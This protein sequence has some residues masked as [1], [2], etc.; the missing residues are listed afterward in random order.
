MNR[1]S[2]LFWLVLVGLSSLG[3]TC[4]TTDECEA[5]QKPPIEPIFKIDFV[6]LHDD[7]SPYTGPV[8]VQF[9]KNYCD[10]TVH[11][12]FSDFGTTNPDGSWSPMITPIYKLENERDFILIEL[13]VGN[14]IIAST[15]FYNDIE[16]YIFIDINTGLLVFKDTFQIGIP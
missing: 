15:L 7:A 3:S 4:I 12:V 6:V 13:T 9:S 16:P 8:S 5:T 1:G 10:G 2:L 11:G 14:Q